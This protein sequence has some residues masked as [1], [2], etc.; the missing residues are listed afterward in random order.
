M[1]L[2]FRCCLLTDG[3]SFDKEIARL[4]SEN[5]AREKNAIL[6][7]LRHAVTTSTTFWSNFSNELL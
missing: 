3:S 5:V 4:V 6:W 7:N 2:L 1:L